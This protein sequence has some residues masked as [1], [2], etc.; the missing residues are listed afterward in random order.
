VARETPKAL[1]VLAKTQKFTVLV[2]AIPAEVANLLVLVE[3]LPA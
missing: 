1:T 2:E 3:I